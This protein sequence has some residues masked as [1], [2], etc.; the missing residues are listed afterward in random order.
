M[1]DAPDRHLGFALDLLRTH[2]D[3]G[4]GNVVVSPWSVSSAL[5]VLAP[6][7]DEPAR[8]EIVRALASGRE[9]DDLVAELAG[10]ASGLT[11][12]RPAEDGSTLAV[13][14]TLWVDQ[15]R[16]PAPAFG[17]G[18]DRWPGAG[19]RTVPLAANPDGARATIN[20]DVARTTRDLIPEILPAGSITPDDRAV[21]VNALYL[22]AAWLEP[23][24]PADTTAEPFHAP[25]GTRELPTMRGLREVAYAGGEAEYVALPLWGGLQAEIVLSPAAR[26]AAAGPDAASLAELRR[27]ATTHRVLLHLPRFRVTS[28]TELT[29]PLQTLGVHR[30]FDAGALALRQ[31][32]VEEPLHVAGVY[33]AAV[34]RAD[35]RGIEGA[36]ATAIVARAVAFLQLP[37]VEM[38][39]D[40]PFHVLISDRGT[41]AVLFLASVAEP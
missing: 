26:T 29:R 12:D 37:E 39:V 6:G 27:G 25:S 20:A 5:A 32:V 1:S 24:S 23:F 16:T 4:R 35:E 18:L 21:I 10:D 38:R 30:I 9:S 19:V 34:L 13:A 22:L 17:A 31:V 7:C 2:P 14:N 3:T 8:D 40:R 33:H 36:A 15:S 11:A 28:T 41:G